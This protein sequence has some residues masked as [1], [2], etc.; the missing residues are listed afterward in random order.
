MQH[1]P[2]RLIVIALAGALAVA[3]SACGGDNGIRISAITSTPGGGTPAPTALGTSTSA[4]EA[5]PLPPRP[6]N[7]FASGRNVAAYLAGGEADLEG[8]LPELV[9][10]WGLA[11][12]VEGPRCVPVDFDNDGRDEWVFLVSF[13]GEGDRPGDSDLWFF[14]DSEADYRYFNSGRALANAGTPGFEIRT[15]EDL[16]GDG[17]P[18]LAATWQECGASTCVTSLIIATQHGGTLQNLAPSES[19]VET[20]E[21]FEVVDGAIRML[22]GVV[23]SVGAGP[24]RQSTLVVDW[25]GLRFRVDREQG[26]PIYL[27]HLVNDADRAFDAGDYETAQSLYRQ[28]SE[29]SELLDW[30]LEVGQ[31]SDRH[32]LQAYSLFRAALTAE[33]SGDDDQALAFLESA[34]SRHP[35]TMHAAAAEAYGTALEDGASSAEAC[36]AT[37]ALLDT[38]QPLYTQFWD[39]GTS[40]PERAVFTLCR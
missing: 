11:E 35:A 25:A 10:E 21:E 15:V 13:P 29:D 37:E 8:C 32:E 23:Q 5:V 34:V 36:D 30:K 16:S 17:L 4:A 3:G 38:F 20:L 14:D 39:F 12:E 24:Q 1:L 22:G 33:R 2:R 31:P 19:S 28:V 27:V 6:E 9:E 18:D 40:N 26:E 7:P